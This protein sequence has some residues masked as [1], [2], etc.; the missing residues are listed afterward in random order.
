[1]GDRRAWSEIVTVP[2]FYCVTV[3]SL[4]GQS[5]QGASRKIWH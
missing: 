4:G 1:M 2:S 5:Y 3:P